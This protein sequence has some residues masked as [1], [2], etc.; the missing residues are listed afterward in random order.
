MA[1]ALAA[2]RWA[3]IT[4]TCEFIASY[5]CDLILVVIMAIYSLAELFI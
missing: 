5:P 4:F 1:V 2:K 3:G